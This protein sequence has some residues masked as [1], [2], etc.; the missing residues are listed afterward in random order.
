[1][2][3]LVGNRRT[4]IVLI[5]CVLLSI[6]LVQATPDPLWVRF[7][8]G[9][10]NAADQSHMVVTDRAGNCYVT[11]L[12]QS[13][14]N[15][16]DW[17]TIKYLPNG[18]TGWVRRFDRGG[19][20]DVANALA[21]DPAG[22]IIV[23]GYTSL[24]NNNNITT[25][26][27]GPLGNH[28]YIR[29]FDGPAQS[30]DN[31]Y[32]VAVDSV[33]NAYVVGY[34][35]TPNNSADWVVIKYQPNGD[36]AWVRTA[37]GWGH[38]VDRANAV[39][40]DRQGNVIVAGY[41][42]NVGN[43]VNMG[44]IKYDA[45]GNYVYVREYDGPAHEQ[46]MAYD[47]AL[48]TAGNAYITGS[49]IGMT[50]SDCLTIK[51]MPN[52]GIDWVSRYNGPADLSDAGYAIAVDNAGNAYVAGITLG[53]T[54]SADWLTIKYLPNGDTAWVRRENGWGNGNDMPNDLAVGRAGDVFVTGITTSLGGNVNIGVVRYLADGTLNWVWEYDGSSAGWD[55]GASVA[56]DTSNNIFLTGITTSTGTGHD[57]VTI[58]HAAF[59]GTREEPQPAAVRST[60][61][62]PSVVA[63]NLQLAENL[64]GR[65]LILYDAAGR[66]QRTLVAGNNDLQGV[67]PGVYFV[68]GGKNIRQRVV[69][70]P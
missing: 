50:N 20:A 40:V 27:Y 37:D 39:A 48:D 9:P 31:S 35:M 17:V 51:Y 70:M 68:D 53:T 25:V 69:I 18:S 46:D 21:V 24:N 26:K 64:R 7:Y 16:T 30:D 42:T 65:S 32:A 57:F 60:V 22:N 10:D 52:G 8:N 59:A 61:L 2:S 29:E 15:S 49:S 33:G 45:N 38:G 41:T 6:T 13:L 66:K 3:R 4:G 12:S 5:A 63:G 14:T 67:P 1:M 62:C 11:G 58:K 43:N 47:L 44:I 36:V 55:M 19:A 23:T 54:S 34:V 28:V 56:L